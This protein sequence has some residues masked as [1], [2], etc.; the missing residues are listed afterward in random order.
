MTTDEFFPRGLRAAAVATPRLSAT[1]LTDTSG[2]PLGVT[3]SGQ[4]S[5]M[6]GRYNLSDATTLCLVLP[7]VQTLL[8]LAATHKQPLPFPPPSP[9]SGATTSFFERLVLLN[10]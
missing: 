5:E 6:D 7:Y 4:H 9:S 3:L 10:I 8:T 1:L 2:A